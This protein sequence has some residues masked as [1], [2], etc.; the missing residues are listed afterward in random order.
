MEKNGKNKEE[1][2]LWSYFKKIIPRGK[3][4]C[5]DDNTLAAYLDG[6]QLWRKKDHIEGH[7]SDCPACLKKLMD[8]RPLLTVEMEEAPLNF[9]QKAKDFVT[10]SLGEVNE[11][12]LVF[13]KFIFQPKKSLAWGV[14]PLLVF[15]SCFTGVKF[16][17]EIAMSPAMEIFS[18]KSNNLVESAVDLLGI[19]D[20]SII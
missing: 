10:G 2:Q 12:S 8:M 14:V 16:G 11:N 7:L 18:G 4:P 5:L 19:Q 6:R 9:K 13:W 1:Q 17:R 15:T 20:I 3:T